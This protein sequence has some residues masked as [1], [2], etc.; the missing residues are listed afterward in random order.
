MLA[1]PGSTIP[2]RP[3]VVIPTS[4]DNEVEELYG[5]YWLYWD[6]FAAAHA[7]PN[8]DP[9]FDPLRS[10]STDENWDSL[11]DQLAMFASDGLVLVLPKNSITEHLVRLP[12]A[13]VLSKEEGAEVIL[14]DC[15]IDDFV[16]Q[17]V[18]G[19]VLSETREAKLMNVV[20]RVVNGEWR[21]DGVARATAES[22]GFE[23]CEQLVSS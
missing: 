2:V 20:M 13:S 6:A 23:Q 9:L 15:W 8:A 22:D 10:L 18:D 4:W 17:T 14:Q 3:E 5:R 1:V 7:P 12:N 11:N 21:V 16:Q 19:T